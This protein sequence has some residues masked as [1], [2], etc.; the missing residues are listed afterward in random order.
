MFYTS[1]FDCQKKMRRLYGVTDERTQMAKIRY[2][3]MKDD[4]QMFIC[5]TLHEHNKKNKNG[6]FRNYK[7]CGVHVYERKNICFNTFLE[8][9][10]WLTAAGIRIPCIT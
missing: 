3:Q 6:L 8:T 9:E 2:L 4:T 7:L 1:V 5:R 10:L